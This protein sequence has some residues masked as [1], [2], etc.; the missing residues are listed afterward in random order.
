VDLTAI[1]KWASKNGASD[2]HIKVG[3]PPMV[4]ING[5]IRSIPKAPKVT[6]ELAG[7][8]AWSIMNSS[9]RERFKVTND[10]DMAWAA[11]NLGRFRVNVFRQR[12]RIGMVLR[13]IPSKVFTIKELGLPD[14][15]RAMA[16]QNRGLLLVTGV[17]GSG[18]STTLAAMIEEINRTKSHHILT[19][20]DPIEFTFQDRVAIINQ[21]EVGQDSAS[22]KSALR[23]ALRQDPDVI[24]VGEL[25][26]K[27]TMEIALTAAETGHLVMGTLHTL[28]APQAI[29]RIV[30]FFDPHHQKRVRHQISGSL[31]GIVSQRLVPR[32]GGGRIAA[33]EVMVN[34]GAVSECIVDPTRIREITDLL[35]KGTA[36]YGTQTFDQS[37][38]WHF[39][40]GTITKD[41]ALGYASNPEDLTLR[42]SGIASEDWNK[43]ADSQ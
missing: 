40:E 25:R 1:A 43:P 10:L 16:M 28:N 20:E 39:Q 29:S 34:K 24:L 11:P 26:D 22:F 4:R 32:I 38:Y 37:L 42:M 15:I 35:S 2:I 30:D 7:Q 31:V 36:Q 41:D 19:I 13:I 14:S 21:R 8:M 18:K 23:A 9:Q 33:V 12:A 6:Q 5:E 3:R 17:T 27:E